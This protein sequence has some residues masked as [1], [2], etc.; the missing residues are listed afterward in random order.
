MPNVPTIAEVLAAYNKTEIEEYFDQLH[1]AAVLATCQRNAY[2]HALELLKYDLRPGDIIHVYNMTHILV[3]FSY[4]IIDAPSAY[5]CPLLRGT[6]TG[7]TYINL[8][9]H[10]DKTQ[11]TRKPHK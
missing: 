3:D 2:A 1:K 5:D 10:I 9:R 8:W 4:E 7:Q 6:T 11:V